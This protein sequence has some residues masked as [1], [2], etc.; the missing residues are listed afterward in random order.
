V[1]PTPPIVG[2]GASAGGVEAL[3]QFFKAVPAGNRLAFVVVTHLSPDHKSMLA[4]ILG[5]ATQMQVVDAED[6]ER[7]DAEHVY[8]LPPGAIL[9]IGEGRLR[10]HPTR[11]GDRERAPIDVFFNSLAEDQAEHA[12]GVVLSGSGHDGTLGI[13]AIKENG[14]LTIAQG[15]KV[16]RPR[17]AEMAL[18]AVAA[19]FIDLELPV[20][21][22][23]RR[24]I[25][26]V[27]DWSAFD[28]EKP[29]E[30]LAEVY[31]V[32]R[33][34]TGHDFSE[35]KDRTFQRRV[36]RRMQVVQTAKLEDYVERLR[37]DPEQVHA[38]FRDL[39]IGVTDFFRDAAAFQDLEKMVIPKLFEGRGA[40]DEVRVW[41]TGCSTGE[42]AYSIAILLR[43]QCEKLIAPPKVQ[44]FASDIDEAAMVVARA[45]RYPGNLVKEV[46]PERLRRFFVHEGSTYTVLKELREMCIFSTHSVIRDPPFSRLDLISCRNLLIYLKPSLQAQVIPVFHYSLRPG[47]YLFLGGSENLSRHGELFVTIDRKSR[48]SQR[49]DLVS[50]PALPLRQFL[51]NARRDL[52]GAESSGTLLQR[53]DMLRRIAATVVERFAPSYVIIDESGQTLFFSSGTGKYLQPAA[54]PPNGDIVAMARPGLRVDL[55]AALL[56]A[57]ETGQRV[58]R[59]RVAVQINGGTQRVSVAVEPIGH[60]K[61]TAYAVVFI[62]RGPIRTDEEP[63][64]TRPGNEDA[65]IKQI[66]QEL[67]DTKERLQSTIEELETA[68]EEF[69]SSNEELLSVNEELQSTNEELETSKEEL[70]SVNEELQ[71]VNNEL[72][73]KVEELDRANADL[74][75]LFQSTQVATIFL[76]RNLVIRSFTPEV[77]KLFNIIPGDQGRPL[78]DLAG[79]LIYPNLQGDISD[80]FRGK[81]IERAVSLPDRTRHYLARLLPYRAANKS[82]EGVLLTFVDVTNLVTAET[83]QQVL[84][85]ELS[86]R[87]KNT[88]AVVSSI[89][90]RTLPGSQAKTDLLGRY[91][92]LGHTHDLLS[93]AGWTIARLR[94]VISTELTPYGAH[95]TVNGPE[96]M[97]KAQTALFLAL[98]FHELATN[99]A[100]YGALSTPAGRVAI[101]WTIAGDGPSRLELTWIEQ[102]GPKVGK[103]TR[104]GFGTELIE[105]GIRFELQGEAELGFV[106]GGLHCRIVIP[107][108]PKYFTFASPPSRPA[109]EEAAS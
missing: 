44:I 104:Q 86:H 5:R 46:S 8:V 98:V 83:Q 40:D 59:D 106:H 68:N 94:E 54:G 60:G 51:P 102:G 41:V 95:V 56:R 1:A 103:P 48:I 14:G 77:T 19:G 13:K 82:I 45:A 39:L 85:A 16:S 38:L 69:R 27:R 89:A 4:E 88:L 9:T 47:G 58:L 72:T 90:E 18:S 62:D 87:V 15:S 70:Q 75:N 97:L 91:H 42:E 32:L 61:E 107:A 35:Y 49:R 52:A 24:I 73:I 80:V 64:A 81:M 22:I 43:E 78:T 50:R 23:P 93:A 36:Q 20:E 7:V 67:Q 55:R 105:R 108:D 76:D 53:S 11:L 63:E 26:Y 65:S 84:T 71:T 6:G 3:E 34:R 79:H 99:A 25:A 96:V 17:F 109:T 33:S 29:G 30:A 74:T 12:I 66:E 2:I 28:P 100:K 101:T 10:L 57:K 31:S 37:R 92:A 21:E